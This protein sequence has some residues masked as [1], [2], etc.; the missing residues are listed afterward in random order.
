MASAVVWQQGA[1]VE[2]DVPLDLLAESVTDGERIA[3]IGLDRSDS[4]AIER[5]ADELGLDAFAVEDA[6][7]HQ[8]RPKVDRYAGHIFL[9]VY[10]ARYDAGTGVVHMDEVAVFVTPKVLV[11]VTNGASPLVG[12]RRRW[13]D[14]PEVAAHGVGGLLHGLLD[15]VVE[16]HFDVLG[17]LDDEIEGIEDGLFEEKPAP[18]RPRRT[19]R[20]RR[21]LVA[22]R[23]LAVPMREVV[24]VF[25][26]E[27]TSVTAP[28]LRPHFQDL[29]DDV[30]RVADWTEGL[31]DL[32]TTIFET[33]LSL[34]D[35]LL[36]T[37][38]KRLTGWAAIIAVPTA[39]TGFYGMNVPYPGFG[40][41]AGFLAAVVVIAVAAGGLFAVFRSKDWI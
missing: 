27:D 14:K 30:L 22:L 10:P 32:V 12:T 8:H 6:L 33:N 17:A 20:V 26:R 23:R 21:A 16:S 1:V 5:L 34:Q 37:V 13:E 3:W 4:A 18:G 35:H 28:D 15:T 7:S 2:R 24:L 31:R 29:Y 9:T 41:H 39:V 25:A 36:N 40:R 11:T 38:M 19:Y